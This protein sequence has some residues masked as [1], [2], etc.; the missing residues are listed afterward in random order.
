MRCVLWGI[1][2]LLSFAA[3]PVAAAASSIDT[4]A[5]V[6]RAPDEEPPLQVELSESSLTPGLMMLALWIPI[7]GISIGLALEGERDD[8][9]NQLTRNQQISSD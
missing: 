8:K 4:S 7:A 2:A 6:M 5:I 9:P 1:I 3:A